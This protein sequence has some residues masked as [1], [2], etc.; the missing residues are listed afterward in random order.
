MENH[1]LFWQKNGTTQVSL[2]EILK[3]ATAQGKTS[4]QI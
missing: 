2:F 3:H 4:I 1:G